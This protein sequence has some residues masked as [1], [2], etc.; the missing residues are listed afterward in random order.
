MLQNKAG[1]QQEQEH[2][3]C[4]VEKRKRGLWAAQEWREVTLQNGNRLAV[5]GDAEYSK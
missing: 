2:R 5:L 4:V 3:L 1:I